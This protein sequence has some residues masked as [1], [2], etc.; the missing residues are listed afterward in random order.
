MRV[1]GIIL[2]LLAA[3]QMQAKK[4]DSLD[5][6]IG[7]M[8]MIGINERTIL[9]PDDALVKDLRDGKIGGVVLFEK[10]IAK[11]N[12]GDS[13]KLLIQKLQENAGIPLLVSIDEEG[14]KVHRLKEK[15]GFLTVPSAAYLGNLDNP[16]S[17]LYHNRLLA[18]LLRHL[19][20]NL[21]YAPTVDLAV[22]PANTVIVKNGRSFGEN[23]TQVVTHAALCIQAHHEFGIKTSLK[24][25][26]GHGSSA[27]DSHL[28]M[29][30]V[31]GTWNIEELL[32]YDKLLRSVNYDAVMV[33][34]IINKRWDTT[35]L[36][37]TLSE[38]AISG[39][40][41]TLLGFKGVVISDDM[42]MQ[43]ISDNYGFEAAIMMAINAGVDIVVF[44]NTLPAKDKL[45]T[46]TQI[47]EV[48]RKMVKKKK[49]SRGRIN[50]AY[51][52]I[53]ALKNKT[54]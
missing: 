22:N 43:A 16:D 54:F 8:I 36:P 44:A 6:K 11:T 46:A 4:N 50:E 20:I 34:H 19:G 48:I 7:Q 13:L 51:T 28:G 41:R 3:L 31:T 14:G 32:P 24:H 35:L 27:G 29:V 52:R 25:F 5:I 39:L 26:P 1:T 47:H 12:S 23:Y 42:Q 49:I 33:G 2:L 45:V 53:M 10:N 30:D 15:Y 21:N 37:A 17:T 9:Q 18:A 38:P 40:L